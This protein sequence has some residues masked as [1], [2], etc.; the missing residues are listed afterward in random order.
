MIRVIEPPSFEMVARG[1]RKIDLAHQFVGEAQSVGRFA[2]R[3]R[4]EFGKRKEIER[5]RGAG[6]RIERP[7]RLQ[8]R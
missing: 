8:A 7:R 6:H 4:L 2:D 3:R 1:E 5:A